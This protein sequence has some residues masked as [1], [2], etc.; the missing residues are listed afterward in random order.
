MRCSRCDAEV[1]VMPANTYRH[2]D[3]D[4]IL[5]AAALGSGVAISNVEGQFMCPGCGEV[6]HNPATNEDLTG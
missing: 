3:G 6:G 4:F 5:H 1:V 2:A